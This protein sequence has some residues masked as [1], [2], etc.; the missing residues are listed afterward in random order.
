VRSMDEF[1][2]SPLAIDFDAVVAPDV[3][4]RFLELPGAVDVRGRT[5]PIDYD[6]EDVSGT[7]RGVA[8]LRLPE[9]LARTLTAEELPEL[10]RPIRFTVLR[11]PR[12]AV[13]ATTLHELQDLLDRPWSPDEV[14]RDESPSG[15]TPRDERRVRELAGEFRREKRPP[16]GRAGRR[17]D[18]RGPGHRGGGGD[19]AKPRG[20]GPGGAAPRGRRR[21]GR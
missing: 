3:R 15:L 14:V 2:A 1:R 7:P 5:V 8:R 4:A 20:R 10:D 13:R 6:V 18:G 16:R 9:K 21:R 12:G 11:G 17:V 19:G